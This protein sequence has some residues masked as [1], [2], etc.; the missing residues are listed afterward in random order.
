M[1]YSKHCYSPQNE[2]QLL[3]KAVETAVAEGSY[4]DEYIAEN[5]QT[6]KP[7]HPIY[8]TRKSAEANFQEQS[9]YK[10][11]TIEKVFYNPNDGAYYADSRVT[12]PLLASI[13][14]NSMGRNCQYMLVLNCYGQ[15]ME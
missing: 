1:S 13:S 9:K 2:E 4:E 3:N 6:G 7:D 12:D 10:I 8:D 14:R 5:P 11:G 15:R